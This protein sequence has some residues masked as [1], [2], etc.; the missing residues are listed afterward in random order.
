MDKINSPCFKVIAV[1]QAMRH[2][3]GESTFI[4]RSA[5]GAAFHWAPVFVSPQ[6]RHLYRRYIIDLPALVRKAAYFSQILTA[7]TTL[8]GCRMLDDGIR[9]L[10][11]LKCRPR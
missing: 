11:K 2:F 7:S 3:F 9:C 1:L 4:L 5:V 10:T 6:A 8:H